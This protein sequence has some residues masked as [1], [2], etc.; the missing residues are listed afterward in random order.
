MRKFD[1]SLKFISTLYN[2]FKSVDISYSSHDSDLKDD[3][4]TKMESLLIAAVAQKALIEGN[5]VYA[6]SLDFK[7]NNWDIVNLP[8]FSIEFQE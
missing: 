5:T 2:T 8:T 7:L 1:P 6:C 4:L 3:L